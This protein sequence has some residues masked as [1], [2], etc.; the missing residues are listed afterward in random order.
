[1]GG[2]KLSG[3]TFSGV[4]LIIPRTTMLAIIAMSAAWAAADHASR[5][6]LNHLHL[7]LL[8]FLFNFHCC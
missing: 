6:Q 3:D 2:N 4:H 7:R 5:L 1:M 8:E